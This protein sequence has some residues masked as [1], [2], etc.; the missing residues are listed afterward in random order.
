MSLKALANEETLLRTHC[1]RHKCF[2]AC[3]RAQ[4]LWRTQKMFL[5]LF[6]NIL[7]PQQMFPSLRSTETQRSFC[8]PRVCASKKHHEQ[9]CV[10]NNGFSFT[11]ALRT[12]ARKFSN[13]EFFS[14][15]FTS[16]RWRFSMSKMLK[17]LGGHRLRFG[18]NMPGRSPQIWKNRASLANN[19]CVCKPKNIAMKSLKLS[20]LC[21]I[22]FKWTC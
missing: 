16:L 18:E 10:L 20:V 11:R 19:A 2:P 8:V 21:Q 17:K 7:C 22:L 15:T 1:C 12:F 5:I 3:S 13:I 6:R 14:E 4:H 9:Q